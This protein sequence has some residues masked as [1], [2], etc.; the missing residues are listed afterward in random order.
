[1][2]ASSSTLPPLPSSETGEEND[3]HYPLGLTPAERQWSDLYPYVARRG[4]HLRSRYRP[5]WIG[6]WIQEGL[7]TSELMLRPTW[8]YE[9]EDAVPSPGRLTVIDATRINDGAPVALKLISMSAQIN[10]PDSNEIEILQYLS[11]SAL[12]Q[13]PRNHCIQMIDSFEVFTPAEMKELSAQGFSN[14]FIAVFPFA[15]K[16]TDIPFR[17]V[18]EGL[19]F[20]R[21]V[22]EGLAF[23]HEH[24]IAHRDIRSENLMMD[25]A[26][27]CFSATYPCDRIDTPVRYLFIDLGSSTKFDEH[28]LV[29]FRHGWHKEIPEIYE[30]DSEGNRV[31]TRLYDPFK[32]DVFVLGMVLDVYF[33]K[34]ISSLQPLFSFMQNSSP[35]HRPTA[36]EA[37]S[38]FHQYTNPL[39][40]SRI[41]AVMPIAD[42]SPFGDGELDFFTRWMVRTVAY[43]WGWIDYL[44]LVYKVL[45]EGHE[46][47]IGT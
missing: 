36:S 47:R 37:L 29:E 11:S 10:T 27:Q 3:P 32:G 21:Q 45:W 7:S 4:Y 14:A 5:G 13:D 44:R 41:H 30:M 17:L 23:L 24:N 25:A 19:D 15:R 2:F 35:A 31:P 1:M 8:R 39:Y 12:A 33:G 34:S 20:V 42:P 9:Y 22:L 6:S 28:R 26:S 18:W 38:L 40:T 46:L 43:L 16:W